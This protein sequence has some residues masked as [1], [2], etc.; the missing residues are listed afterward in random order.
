MANLQFSKG[1]TYLVDQKNRFGFVEMAL[2]VSIILHLVLCP[3]T[4]VEESFN[5]QAMH[6]VVF[7]Q[8]NLT[9]YDHNMFPGVVPRT[10][11]GALSIGSVAQVT[12]LIFQIC[13]YVRSFWFLYLCRGLLGVWVWTSLCGLKVAIAKRFGLNI[14]FNFTLLLSLQFHLPFYASRSLPNTFALAIVME[15]YSQWL[16]V[17]TPYHSFCS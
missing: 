16:E 13:T 1:L 2:L 12:S 8:S 6:D 7:Y 17:C 14:S 15:A 9:K 10:F 5:M 11:L 3:Y 4:K